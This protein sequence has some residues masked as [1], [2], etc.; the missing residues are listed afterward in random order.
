MSV[1]DVYLVQVVTEVNGVATAN[2]YYQ[3]Q[4]VQPGSESS[5]GPGLAWQDTLMT[6]YKA[7]LSAEAT[8]VCIA[9]KKVFPVEGPTFTDFVTE[10]GDIAGDCLPSNSMVVLSLYGLTGGVPPEPVRNS[11]FLTGVPEDFHTN[12]NINVTALAAYGAFRDAQ[13]NTLINAVGDEYEMVVRTRVPGPGPTYQYYQLLTSQ[14]RPI[15]R[16]IRRRTT[17]LCAAP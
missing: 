9:S 6:P 7:I 16:S 8:A 14:V 17:N 13:F 4:T 15:V 12:G 2:N 11:R 10:V 1:D 5:D 3:K